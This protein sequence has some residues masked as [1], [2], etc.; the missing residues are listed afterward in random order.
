MQ[1]SLGREVHVIRS[2]FV[3][4]SA[5]TLCENRVGLC[6][7]AQLRLHGHMTRRSAAL[8]CRTRSAH[9][10]VVV[11]ITDA[12]RV[13]PLTAM[14][15]VLRHVNVKNGGPVVWRTRMTGVRMYSEYC[16]QSI[17]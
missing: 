5:A 12:V 1:E 15:V 3:L 9:T 14:G 8:I 2:L 11:H 10:L 16:R 7:T 6:R 4:L 13:R 17:V